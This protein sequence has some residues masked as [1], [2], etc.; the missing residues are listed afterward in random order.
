M[1]MT[2]ESER[3]S[4]RS[5]RTAAHPSSSHAPLADIGITRLSELTEHRAADLLK[6]RA[7]AQERWRSASRLPTEGSRL[8]NEDAK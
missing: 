8:R 1:N 3:G 5:R 2:G 6:L 7:W 4:D